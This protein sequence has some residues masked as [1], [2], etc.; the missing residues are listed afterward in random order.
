MNKD[1]QDCDHCGVELTLGDHP[2]CCSDCWEEMRKR[3]KLIIKKYNNRKYNS[4]RIIIGTLKP[5]C[6]KSLK[7]SK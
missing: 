3:L 5:N 2:S 6:D 1:K 4:K 7:R